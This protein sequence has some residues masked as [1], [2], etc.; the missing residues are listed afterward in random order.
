MRRRDSAICLRT[1][2]YSETS[3]VVHFLTRIDG[4]VSL[5]AKGSKRPKSKTGGTLDLLSEG[6]LVYTT[7]ASS[8]GA[9]GTLIEFSETTTH[10]DLRKAARTLYAALYMTE[11]TGSLLAEG[12]PHTEVF[13]LLH[14]GL[15]RVGQADAPI[16]AVLAYFQWRLLRHVGLLGDMKVCVTCGQKPSHFSSRQGGMLCPRCA[17]TA[18]EKIPL[19]ET[20]LVGLTAL[21]AAEAGKKVSLSPAGADAANRILA[22]HVEQ[23]TGKPLKTARHAILGTG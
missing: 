23:Q 10:S 1:T 16:S 11:L 8:A 19:D 13:D 18:A 14:S 15:V 22:Y 12:D 4:V 6:D 17:A 21:A 7:S 9:L 20:A 5:L 2:D 3:Q